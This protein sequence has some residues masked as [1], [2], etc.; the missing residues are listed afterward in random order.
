MVLL[1]DSGVIVTRLMPSD[2]TSG[3]VIITLVP[4]QTSQPSTTFPCI[5]LPV[6]YYT[7]VLC[8]ISVGSLHQTDAPSSLERRLCYLH[9]LPICVQYKEPGFCIKIE[10]IKIYIYIH[11]KTIRQYS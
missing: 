1:D 10:I 5:L 9:A 2:L 6:K 7:D 8:F 4:V 11:T 3:P